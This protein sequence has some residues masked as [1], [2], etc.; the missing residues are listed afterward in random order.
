MTIEAELPDG[1]IL[2]FPDGTPETV[3]S[4]AA[5]KYI[6]AG[7]GRGPL[8]NLGFGARN[9]MEAASELADFVATPIRGP[10]NAAANA[11]VGH[12]V[13]PTLT[14]AVVDPA[15]DAMRMPQA[16]SRTDQLVAAGQKGAAQALIPFPGASAKTILGMVKNAAIGGS[17][18]VGADVGA[19]AAPDPYKP[20]AALGS[21]LLAGLVTHGAIEAPGAVFKAAAPIVEPF[22]AGANAKAAE[23][24]AARRLHDAASDPAAAAAALEH[25][26]EIL[27]GSQ[28]TTFQQTGDLG[29]GGLER[30]VA[31]RNPEAFAQ[32]RGDQNAARVEALS[33]LQR[34][35]DPNDVAKSL[36]AQFDDLNAHLDADV[37]SAT[38]EAQARTAA[39]G[40][41]VTPEGAGA[42][43]RGNLADNLA[44]AKAADGKLWEAVDPDNNLIGNASETKEAAGKIRAETPKTAKPADGEEAA[45]FKAVDDLPALAPLS[46]IIAL[47]SRVSA[48]MRKERGQDGNP[49]ALRRLTQLRGSIESNLSNTIAHQVSLDDAAVSRGMMG[50]EDTTLARIQRWTDQW[51]EDAGAGRSGA[52]AG[53]Q[54]HTGASAAGVHGVDGTGGQARGGSSGSPRD[55]GLS[56]ELGQAKADVAAH[57]VGQT[58]SITQA[59]RELGGLKIKDEQGAVLAGPDLVGP[60]ADINKAPGLVNNRSG[61]SPENMA[62]ALADRG[63][64]GDK[65]TDNAKALEDALGREGMGSKVY[66]PQ[67]Y[68]PG[69]KDRLSRL[70]GELREAGA[71]LADRP[72]VAAKKLADYRAGIA[73]VRARAEA[74]GIDVHRP[75]QD[76]AGDLA[77]REAIQAEAPPPADPHGDEFDR[78]SGRRPGPSADDTAVARLKAASDA[79]KA[80]KATYGA[81][82]VKGVL[83]E[84]G[85]KGDYRLPNGEVPRKFFRPGPGGYEAMQSLLKAAPEALTAMVDYAATSLRRAAADASGV[86][87]AKK[88]ETWAKA[89]KDALRA[90]PP[91]ARAKFQ[92]AASAGQTVADALANR[93]AR[94]KTAQEGALG[95]VM[96]LTTAEDVTK[97]VGQVLNGRT[98]VADMKSLAKA[99]SGNP[100]A[101]A[102]LRQAVADFM[103]QKLVGNTEAGA[104][105]VKQIKADAYL[106]FIKEKRGALNLVFKPEEVRTMEAIGEDIARSK[107]SE[108]AVKIPGG[109]N[110]AQDQ[111]AARKGGLL[112]KG[113]RTILDAVA[114]VAGFHFGGPITGGAAIVGSHMLQSLRASGIERIDQLLT[115]AMLHPNVAKE[116]LRKA[117]QKLNPNAT[118]PLAAALRTAQ[119]ASFAAVQAPTQDKRQ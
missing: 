63:W 72:N 95:K 83:A 16:S 10:I 77:E 36:K 86:I 80:T 78:L 115:E 98:A 56:A 1:T 57:R 2:E 110:T 54:A 14:E 12:P 42:S 30:G 119:R 76:I 51:L 102:G 117:P 114:G 109:S 88:F 65:P 104:S 79:T 61:L 118:K 44:K 28:P 31:A 7:E 33:G 39:T 91:E 21:G 64:F 40:A 29:L 11:L 18:M 92:D 22:A 41:E 116:L 96:N 13:I 105:G 70:D 69:F 6:K 47:R 19:A 27:P 75:M 32:R 59:I 66:H 15:A 8:G 9:M 4:A 45:I 74:L 89:H 50:P 82:P 93:T 107:R 106:T 34:G 62:Q 49:E 60:L 58:G 67:T 73:A 90:L 94:L 55:Q 35:A 26:G 68:E 46:D 25:D 87:D 103:T 24:A 3:I 111:I 101:R 99:T 97:T 20:A 17:A 84:K 113:G 112:D 100:V 81:D 48:A 37:S 38:S 108:N 5:K 52:L 71:T 43:V 85:L 53:D 23:T